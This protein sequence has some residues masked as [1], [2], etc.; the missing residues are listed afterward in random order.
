MRSYADRRV[1]DPLFGDVVAGR[2]EEVP[3]SD[4][5]VA[6]ASSRAY[7]RYDEAPSAGS[8][9]GVMLMTAPPREEINADRQHQPTTADAG[10]PVA[11]DSAA[12]V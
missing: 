1:P 7:Y 3:S 2:P 10:I 9:N 6:R 8:L 4:A 5:V 12:R 11:N